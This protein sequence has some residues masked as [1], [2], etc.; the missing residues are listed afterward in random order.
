[1]S[2]AVVRRQMDLF[3]AASIGLFVGMS[4]GWMWSHSHAQQKQQQQREQ[5]ERRETSDERERKARYRDECVAPLHVQDTID[6]NRKGGPW[7]MRKKE[8]DASIV[9]SMRGELTDN[10]LKCVNELYRGT[11][12]KR[13][14]EDLFADFLINKTRVLLNASEVDRV[15]L[16]C[17]RRNGSRNG[18]SSTHTLTSIMQECRE[19]AVLKSA[20]MTFTQQLETRKGL[21]V[22]KGYDYTLSSNENYR[23]SKDDAGF[24]GEFAD[25]R[26]TRDYAYHVHYTK[27]RQ[28]WQDTCV[29]CIL[30]RTVPQVRP[31][32]VFTCG[33]MGAGKG[34]TVKW[35]S[36][37]GFFP[38]ENIVRIDPDY[39]KRLMPEWSGYQRSNPKT[40]A[41]LLHRESGF[42]QEIAQE[43]A[44][45]SR[46]HI[47]VDGS[48]RNG[49]WY[50][51][52]F[53]DIRERFPHYRIAIFA[54]LAS[55]QVIEERAL[56]R[57]KRTGRHVPRDVMLESIQA[58][59]KSL[60][61][62]TPKVDFVAHI[63]NE[64]TPT[65]VN[66][67]NVDTSGRWALIEQKFQRVHDGM[68]SFPHA[69]SPIYLR[70]LNVSSSSLAF[71]M[72]DRALSVFRTESNGTVK[73]L[74]A[75]STL[76]E[77][78]AISL[79]NDDLKQL[80]GVPSS[81]SHFAWAYPDVRKISVNDDD[82]SR[83]LYELLAVG[84]FVYVD[85]SG[86][87]V[88][89]NVVSRGGA[90]KSRS[91]DEIKS[92]F[93]RTLRSR[94]EVMN[95]PLTESSIRAMAYGTH[96]QFS[97]RVDPIDRDA[98]ADRSHTR[99]HPVTLRQLRKKGAMLFTFVKPHERFW[100]HS[101]TAFPHGG[102]AYLF[103]KH[104][105]DCAFPIA[106]ASYWT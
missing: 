80:V 9:V 86:S 19:E 95:V 55:P 66:C 42:L 69:I 36:R 37:N 53:Q 44:L 85:K 97:D 3:V 94:F 57:A 51:T 48:L 38:L 22:R 31:W 71:E 78:C 26:K 23:E 12:D 90:P 32:I 28:L 14:P 59:S 17:R 5:D 49:P 13:A 76:S 47:W 74:I 50:A 77:L 52:V 7:K 25:I 43:Q 104:E 92:D 11:E 39:I 61:L 45:R 82:A 89:V 73:T 6:M 35:L 18:G 2:F 101:S 54:V 98:L 33:A 70:S 4:I 99:W 34:F 87:V 10:V 46:Q 103:E 79:D 8:N 20:V 40:A 81:A 30:S 27:E 105:D 16:S 68:D 83:D 67:I 93:Y 58:V 62:L 60:A 106:T 84:G 1:M 24:F 63:L 88:C 29:S 96:I 72:T 75:R 102:F 41:T 21:T 15:L 91:R 100:G 64:T 65:L 56:K